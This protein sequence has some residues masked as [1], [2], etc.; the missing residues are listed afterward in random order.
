M[1]S[2]RALKISEQEVERVRNEYEA[3][4]NAIS[5]GVHWVG[6]EGLI[7][8]EN[9]AAAKMLGYEVSELIGKSAHQVMHHHRADGSIFPVA[10]CSIYATL[11]DGVSRHV[12]NEVFWRKDG[13]SFAVEYTC[14]PTRDAAGCP[15]GSVVTF[16]DATARNKFQDAIQNARLAA[17]S[18]NR[19]KSEFLGNMSH[20]FRTPLNGVIGMSEQLL[21]GPLDPDQRNCLNLI[22]LSGE[23]L[24]I[25]ANNILDFSKVESGKLRL[26]VSDFDLRRLIDEVVELF[27]SEAKTKGLNFAVTV[28]HE[29]PG[30][31]RGDPGRLRQVLSNLIGN[32]V[33]FTAQGEVSLGVSLFAET[34]SNVGLHFEIRDTGAGIEPEAQAR[35]FEAFSQADASDTR[36][37]GGSGLGLAIS[38]RLVELMKGKMSFQSEF[39]KGSTFRFDVELGKKSSQTQTLSHRDLKGLHVLIVSDNDADR[40]MIASYTNSW[41]MRSVCVSN[42]DEAMKVLRRSV[43]DDPYELA[44]LDF[45]YPNAEGLE[46]KR[47]IR[48]EPLLAA[49]KLLITVPEG[50]RF[51]TA[52][53][54]TPGNTN[55]VAK[56][57]EPERMLEQVG[58][59]MSGAVVKRAKQIALSGSMPKRYREV[60]NKKEIKI[61]LAEDNRINQMVFLGVLQKLGYGATLAINGV[62]ALNAMSK[63]EYDIIFMDCQMPEM[64][65]YEATRQIRKG[66]WH[67]PRIIAIT[68]NVMAGDAE[69]CRGVGM[70]DYMSKPVRIEKLCEMLERWLPKGGATVKG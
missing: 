26:E 30:D 13:T 40:E 55:L 49:V 44:I 36:K 53:I 50:C 31:V 59:V 4:L 46:L 7:R 41:N 19:A 69:V 66:K 1:S 8:F 23:S 17:E 61:L 29:V 20:E 63:D 22:R 10:E 38:K 21:G 24:L 35:L 64:D 37:Y 57:I 51:E 34:K 6:V 25:V 52:K 54:K 45:Q 58:E 27:K 28:K 62:E 5:E 43:V 12:E 33:K 14:T 48:G 68:A 67:Q 9:P 65:G 3:V 18:A 32:A 39:G 70:D 42:G 15:N 56:P 2:T 11:R 16:I 60:L 47:V